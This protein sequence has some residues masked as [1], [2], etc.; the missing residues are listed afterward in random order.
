MEEL[1]QYLMN[2]KMA[3]TQELKML[4][5][6]SK[7]IDNYHYRVGYCKGELELAKDLLEILE[8]KNANDKTNRNQS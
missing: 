6:N 5:E 8:W 2:I 7:N 3:N 1:K 4:V